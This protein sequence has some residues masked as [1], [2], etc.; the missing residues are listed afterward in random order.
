LQ[1]AYQTYFDILETIDEALSKR[2]IIP[3]L[4]LL[5]SAIDSFSSLAN[6]SDSTGRQVFKSWVKFWML[7]DNNFALNEDDLYSARCGLLHQQTSESTLTITNKA[8]E[9]YYSWGEVESKGLEFAI[10]NSGKKAVAV[11]V[12]ELIS[13]FRIGMA[14]CL[15]EIYL[16]PDWRKQFEGRTEK[17]FTNIEHQIY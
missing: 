2:R 11:K 13:A 14:N 5:Y 10:N 9:I 6:R 16:D 7:K 8:S 17:L 3:A 1:A 15:N 12:E 4:I